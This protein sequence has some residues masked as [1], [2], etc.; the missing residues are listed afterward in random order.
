MRTIVPTAP[1]A[2]VIAGAV[3]LVSS[4]HATDV[5]R[6]VYKAAPAPAAPYNWTGFYVGGN[7]GY[8]WGN[9]N[10]QLK[11]GGLWLTDTARDDVSL[12]PLWNGQLKPEGFTGGIQAG[13][14]YQI[15]RWMFG[16]EADANRFQLERNFSGTFIADPSGNPYRFTSSFEADWLITVRGRLGYAF[17]RLLVY[18]TGGVAISEQKFAQNITQ[19]NVEFVEE[20]SLSKTTTGF[21][22]GAGV[23]YALNSRWSLKAEYLYIDLG[24]LSFST[25]GSC[26]GADPRCPLYTAAHEADLSASIVRGGINYKFDWGR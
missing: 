12:S 14:N 13:L 2:A 19:L 8:G 3:V 16:V 9:A 4:A 18:T 23:E 5:A 22:L 10:D 20:G 11:F 24:T 6:P 1:I 26:S 25:K 15:G 21:V 17:D 7:A